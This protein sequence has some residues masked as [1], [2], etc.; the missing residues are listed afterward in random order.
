M[1]DLATHLSEM[2]DPKV[3]EQV[4]GI[5]EILQIFDIKVKKQKVPVAGC[6]VIEGEVRRNSNIRVL[7]DKVPIHDGALA[8]LRHHKELVEVVKSGTECGMM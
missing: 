4:V 3:E 1:S 2:L 6:R 8:E 5:A 7:R